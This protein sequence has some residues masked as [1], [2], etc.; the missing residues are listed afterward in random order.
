LK[1]VGDFPILAVSQK[2]MDWGGNFTNYCVGNIGRSHLNIYRQIMIGC[3]QAKTKWVAMA[4]DDIL[5]SW[6]HFHNYAPDEEKFAYDMNKWS[7]FTWNDPPLFSF[8]MK[9]KVVNALIAKREMLKDAMEERFAKFPDESKI[10]LSVWGD[11]GRYEE[12]LHVTIRE[13]EEFYSECP[14]IVFSHPLAYGY[15][16]R[17][18]RKKM[19][20]LK[21]IELPYW[22]KA[23]DILKLYSLNREDYV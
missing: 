21:A 13:T 22:G 9:R 10:N 12:Y 8:R 15:E 6:E 7:I 14:N 23:S 5:Y 11:P 19:G 4:E 1:A 2:P 16:S 3:Q 17:G 20:D 18:K